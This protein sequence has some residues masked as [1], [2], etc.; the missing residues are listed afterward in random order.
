MHAPKIQNV[1]NQDISEQSKKNNAQNS[2]VGG[3]PTLEK[4]KTRFGGGVNSHL[5]TNLFF[6]NF[7]VFEPCV[8]LSFVLSRTAPR[9]KFSPLCTSREVKKLLKNT[10]NFAATNCS[11]YIRDFFDSNVPIES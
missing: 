4:K 9:S 11:R 7:S 6:H 3:A 10:M 5:N 8:T 2:R 1:V